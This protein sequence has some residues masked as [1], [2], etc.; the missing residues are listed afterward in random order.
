MLYKTNTIKF[1][2]IKAVLLIVLLP[3]EKPAYAFL[4]SQRKPDLKVVATSNKL[5]QYQEN[6]ENKG[7]TIGILN[8]L[9]KE[10]KLTANISFMPWARAFSTAEKNANTVIL[11][12]F[13][14]AEREQNFHWI[15]KVSQAARV[16]ISLKS[17][18]ENFIDNIEQ[19][20]E[21]VI[22]VILGTAGFQELI[23]AGFSEHKNLYVVSNDEQMAKLLVNGRVDLAYT[24]PNNIER[25]LRNST[26]SNVAL[27]YQKIT[28]K[29]QR[30]SYIALNKSS[31]E[32]IVKLLKLAAAKYSTTEEYSRLLAQ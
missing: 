24:D 22:A 1:T 3:F 8:G 4:Q 32:R 12:M 16:F 15:I 28:P 14:T 17:K 10:S 9:L 20:K 7:P 31:D 21:K 30:M 5:L 26:H 11:S 25:I 18:P 19:A 27:S 6:G 2:C 23:A 13:R 29:N